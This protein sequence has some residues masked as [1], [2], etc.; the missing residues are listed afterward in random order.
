MSLYLYDMLYASE[1]GKAL[2]IHPFLN[3]RQLFSTRGS[4]VL[5][6]L[7]YWAKGTKQWPRITLPTKQ[8]HDIRTVPSGANTEP[9]S[10]LWVCRV[11]SVVGQYIMTSQV[12]HNIH[13][14]L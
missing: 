11:P 7:L 14:P 8:T 5:V 12:T 1:I 6:G 9:G 4:P 13:C 2:L 10:R 3:N